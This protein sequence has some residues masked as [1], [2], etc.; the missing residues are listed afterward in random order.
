MNKTH[1]NQTIIAFW[2]LSMQRDLKQSLHFR[3]RQMFTIRH[4]TS[5]TLIGKMWLSFSFYITT[6]DTQGFPWLWIGS[7]IQRGV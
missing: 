1:I 2:I 7:C 5:I 4:T 3:R 6:M